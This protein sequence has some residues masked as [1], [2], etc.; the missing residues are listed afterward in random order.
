MKP[1]TKK[2]SP[3]LSH[4]LVTMKQWQKLEDYDT[5]TILPGRVQYVMG[6][7]NLFMGG[8]LMVKGK[9]DLPVAI[10][11]LLM[12]SCAYEK[13]IL[14]IVPDVE[15]Q[16]QVIR[17]V[18]GYL[19]VWSKTDANREGRVAVILLDRIDTL[20]DRKFLFVA[21]VGAECVMA[22]APVLGEM[23][24]ANRNGP[25]SLYL[26]CIEAA[27]VELTPAQE[28]VVNE[29]CGPV[30][31]QDQLAGTERGKDGMPGWLPPHQQP[32]INEVLGTRPSE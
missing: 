24:K 12:H 29:V 16:E 5:T 7:F 28:T 4:A 20:K 23:R 14:V 13:S 17:A 32:K 27:D 8:Q 9:E 11:G 10:L 19:E 3:S 15:M 1:T 21:C 25:D 31:L 6:F 2:A 18:N 26:Y 22:A 30:L